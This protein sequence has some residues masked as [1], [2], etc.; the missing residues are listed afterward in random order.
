MSQVTFD[1]ILENKVKF[2][3]YQ[4]IAF[5]ILALVDLTDGVELLTMSVLMPILQTEWKISDTTIE[6]TTSSFYLGMFAGAIITGRIADMYGRKR[7]IILACFFQFAVS[8]W[9][10]FINSEISLIILRFLYGVCYGFSLPITIS[11]IAEISTKDLR[12]KIIICMN[13]C[14]SI[15]K[16]YGLFLIYICLNDFHSGNWRL[17]MIISAFTSL[18]VAI[19]NWYYLKESPRYYIASG[20]I[21]EGVET[22]DYIG[23]TNNPDYV[24]ID[25]DE[26]KGLILYQRQEF[27]LD[28]K[29]NYK[30]LF[31]PEMIGITL[32]LWA[33]WFAL[34]FIE[35]G[36]YAILP[37]II[38]SG[39][40]GF[41]TYLFAILGELPSI[42]FSL[43]VVDKENF[44]R[45]NTLTYCLILVS[46]LNLII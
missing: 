15:G 38:S 44:G 42:F 8:L 23:N 13:F 6:I 27:N 1:T 11:H 22:L 33:I 37:F 7:T 18:I 40:A 16:I 9:F 34:I 36:Q 35:F 10:S 41:G 43:Y 31:R 46:L 19:G 5:S 21:N 17:M 3:K 30:A 4:Y 12:G 28:D 14:V 2:G 39:G 45:K 20:L 24:N 32:R 26:V 29:S 25:C